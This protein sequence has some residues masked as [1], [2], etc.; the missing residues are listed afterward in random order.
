MELTIIQNKEFICHW[1][2]CPI[3]TTDRNQIE[4]HHIVPKE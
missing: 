2:G 4:F 3:H 1:P